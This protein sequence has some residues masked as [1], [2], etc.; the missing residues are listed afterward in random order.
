MTRLYNLTKITKISP[1]AK[2]NDMFSPILKPLKT[3]RF[4]GFEVNIHIG[5]R[6]AWIFQDF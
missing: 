1:L 3:G 4:S 6:Q 2:K 5:P